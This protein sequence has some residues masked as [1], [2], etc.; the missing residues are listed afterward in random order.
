MHLQHLPDVKFNLNEYSEY[1]DNEERDRGS[2]TQLNQVQQAKGG[3]YLPADSHLGGKESVTIAALDKSTYWST[4][5]KN[6]LKRTFH[7]QRNL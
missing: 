6:F 2:F 4:Y 3:L 5:P 1:P 7:L